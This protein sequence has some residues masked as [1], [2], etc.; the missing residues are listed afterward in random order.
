MSA[1]RKAAFLDRDGVINVDHGYL[2]RWEDFEFV[3]GAIEAMRLLQDRGYLLVI[4]TNQSGVA[5]GMYGEAE[6]QQ[7][8]EQ[9]R[10]HLALQGIELAAIQY[11]PHHEKGTV[12][13][14]AIT[15]DCRKP[16]PGMLL[17]AVQA[18]GIELSQSVMFG[19]KPS[20]I[21]AGAAAGVA[22]AALLATDGRGEPEAAPG[23]LP[24]TFELWRGRSLLDAVQALLRA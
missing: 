17:A 9:L 11:C 13:A 14:Y 20:D 3:P 4:V 12:P 8:H 1:T 5:R 15:C 7:L 16:R 2:Y 6:V 10:A 24:Q 23:G 21:E 22:W 19:D 18:L